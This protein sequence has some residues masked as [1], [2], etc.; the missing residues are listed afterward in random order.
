MQKFG[1]R[2]DSGDNRSRQIYA[3]LGVKQEAHAYSTMVNFNGD[4]CLW[5]RSNRGSAAMD[6]RVI[7]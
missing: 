2:K 3:P 7:P 4:G 5:N 6:R 1:C